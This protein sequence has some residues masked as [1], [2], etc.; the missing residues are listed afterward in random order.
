MNLQQVLNA[1]PVTEAAL[2]ARFAIPAG[3]ATTLSELKE[4]DAGSLD[5]PTLRSWIDEGSP[6]SPWI[7]AASQRLT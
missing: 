4:T 5:V 7:A 2:F 1:Y 3:T 6:G